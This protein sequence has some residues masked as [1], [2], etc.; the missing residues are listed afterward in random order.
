MKTSII[1]L[2]ANPTEK[3]YA[4]KE[5]IASYCDL[6]DEVLISNGG[7]EDL[8]PYIP[9]K[10]KIFSNP[11]PKVWNWAEHAKRLNTLLDEASGD[12]ILKVDIDWVFHENEMVKIR[13]QLLSVKHSIATFQKM[14][15][16]PMCKYI[17]KGEVP[18][19]IKG[20]EKHKI[21]FGRDHNRYTD[22]TYPIWW[23]NGSDNQGVPLGRFMDRNEWGRTG[24][25]FWNFDYT[26][27]TKEI[28]GKMFL[29]MSQSHREYFGK[30]KWGSTEE[31]SLSIF[32]RG[33]KHKVQ[34]ASNLDIV[35][36][37]KYIKNRIENIKEEEFGHSGWGMLI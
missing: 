7:E 33:M 6:A 9:S 32:I 18:I 35:R 19:A 24:C 14:T 25:E 16:Y 3:Q 27:K 12:W 23:N 5:S 22:L 37:P 1:L 30:S 34:S 4:W 13:K 20:S 8:K 10:V 31:E 29:R 17:Q 28:A 15:V 36:L 26:F 2:T 11:D 21:R